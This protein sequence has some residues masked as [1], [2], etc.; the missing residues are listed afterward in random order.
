M[1]HAAHRTFALIKFESCMHVRTHYYCAGP[2]HA[3]H[4]MLSS[5]HVQLIARSSRPTIDTAPVCAHG[6]LH[7]G[8]PSGPM[9]RPCGRHLEPMGLSRAYLPSF[10]CPMKHKLFQNL[11][12]LI[13]INTKTITNCVFLYIL[14]LGMCLEL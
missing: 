13:R 4:E 3:A 7:D 11:K 5:E 1:H 14:D 12:K 2:P 6:G 10:R 9:R 8:S